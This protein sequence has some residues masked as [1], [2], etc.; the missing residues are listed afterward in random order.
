M[1]KGGKSGPAII[2][3][4]PDESLL[5]QRIKKQEMPP[6]KLQEQFSVRGV[7]SAEFEKLSQWIAQGARP[8]NE[9]PL[10]VDDYNDP[11]VKPADRQFWSFRPPVREAV[12]PVA[13]GVVRNPID[14]F[15]LQKLSDK[16]LSF[17]PEAGRLTLM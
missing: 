9:E 12:P 7:D 5:I 17:A 13:I 16:H 14:A 1:L 4:K 8:D 2:P 6:P 3:G 15:L 11:L 10:K